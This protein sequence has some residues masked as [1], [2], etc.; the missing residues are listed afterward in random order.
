MVYYPLSVLMLAGIRDIMII[1]TPVDLP[2]FRRLLG[3]G[4]RFGVRFSFA[5]QP[6]PD[7]IAQAFTIG[8]DWIDGDAC[9]LVLGD[10][11]IFGDHLDRAAAQCRDACTRRDG[12]RLSG[13]RP[14][15]LRRGQLR[16]AGARR[17]RLWKN[18]STPPSNWA[19]TGLYF[20]DDRVTEFARAL[21]PSA[22]G[23]LEITDLNRVY[24]ED[25][26]LHVERLGRGCAWLD[27]GMPDSLLQAATFVQTIQSRQGMLVGC[28]EEVAYPHGIYRRVAIARAGRGARQDRS[29]A[30][31]ART[32][33]RAARM[34]QV[35]ACDIP[36][37]L[38]ITPARHGDARGWFM[39]TWRE[40]AWHA[41]GIA[42]PFVQ[43]NHSFSADARTVRGL[44]CQVAP[45]AQ[46][47][48]VRVLRGAILDVAVD[49]RAGSPSFGQH[50]AASL[51][52]ENGAQL[53][54]PPGFLHGFVHAA[55]RIP[56]SPINA[57]PNTTA[58]PNVA[59]AGTI[60]ISASPGRS[61][62]GAVLSDKDRVLPGLAA[63]RTGSHDRA[64]VGDRGQRTIGE[65]IAQSGRRAGAGGRAAG[66]R[67]RPAGHDRFVVRRRAAAPGGE[68]RGVD[69]GRPGGDAKPTPRGK[70]IAKGRPG[71]PHCAP[72]T[73][74]G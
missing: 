13:A 45:F 29:G 42:L 8:A 61:A 62:G 23:E 7:G 53:W 34:M 58:R 22:R 25:G 28:P 74:W 15:T 18:R 14:G 43:D 59:C 64:P 6:T 12:V 9:A 37:V 40:S 27:A 3:D 33:R 63:A 30:A 54:V 20:Y 47:K 73:G 66:L 36:A 21:Q 5:E 38:L 31:A 41:A 68:R 60:R 24:L 55:S 44:H 50:V 39:E 10:N 16:C 46:G 51:S 49:I 70:P 4:S 71:W 67:F 26:S 35:R 1:S 57:P 56:K 52:A 48:L 2:Q 72:R 65:R 69:R 19:V 17:S 32:G 11:L